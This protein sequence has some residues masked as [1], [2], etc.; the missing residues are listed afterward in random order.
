M[1]YSRFG[2]SK[3]YA[4]LL[5]QQAAAEA[6]AK[7]KA[8]EDALAKMP[9]IT[10]DEELEI[11]QATMPLPTVE[12]SFLRRNAVPLLVGGGVLTLGLLGMILLIKV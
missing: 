7:R 8:D 3:K 5:A 2:K 1:S 11:L 12:V 10:P 6:A 4:V 9:V